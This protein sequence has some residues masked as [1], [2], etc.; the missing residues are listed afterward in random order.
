M[1]RILAGVFAL[2][3]LAAGFVASPFV[4]A[5]LIREAVK[6]GDSEYL[7]SKIEWPRVRATMKASLGR[8]ADL[9]EYADVGGTEAKPGL[10]KRFKNY[11]GRNAVEN[12]VESYVTPE[13]LPE[14]FSYRKAYR[15]TVLGDATDPSTLPFHE[16][17]SHFWHRV[18]RAEFKSP[19]LFEIVMADSHD[20]NRL[21]V[22]LFELH[23]FEWR[24]MELHIKSRP[25]DAVADAAAPAP[26]PE[27]N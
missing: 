17:V 21:I 19:T 24:L 7:E 4:T 12:F 25:D 2:V 15:R 23:G 1:K 27:L 3:L 18:K 13:G 10:W 22:S 26:Q 8:M 16:R 6:S 14:L 5:W 9:P 20:P 11:L